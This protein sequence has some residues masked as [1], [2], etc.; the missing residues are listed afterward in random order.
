ML[1]LLFTGR[2]L[3][4]T[5]LV[6][7]LAAVCVRLG[8]WQ[9]DRLAQRRAQNAIIN[10][11]I[12]QPAMPID[13]AAVDL[14]DM[15]YRRVEV[16]GVFDPAQ[17]LVLRNRALEG[18]PGMHVLTPLRISQDA[19]APAAVLVDRGWLPLEFVA[20]DERRPYAAPSGEVVITGIARRSQAGLGGPPDPALPAGETR[21][22]AWFRV[23]I[24]QIEQQAG[25]SLL[26]FFVEQIP[27][28]DDPDL[29]R[30]TPPADLGEGS[31]LSY[32]V[33]W[34]SFALILLV[35]YG[36]FTTQRLR[37]PPAK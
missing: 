12:N 17:E 33:Q 36:A 23:D 28:A 3:W 5:L 1:R 14:E 19:G 18:I 11:R 26:P 22:D 13:A 9:L 25:Y 15:D 8:F 4:M 7:A 31:H 21:R 16:R 34:F 29:P 6:I 32:A 10:A 24:A 2:R 37:N 30:R 35:G 27:A 20:P